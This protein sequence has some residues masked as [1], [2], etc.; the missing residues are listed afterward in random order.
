MLNH[1]QRSSIRI[2]VDLSA[3][4]FR[5]YTDNCFRFIFLFYHL[6]GFIF[7]PCWQQYLI[8][9]DIHLAQYT[10]NQVNQKKIVSIAIHVLNQKSTKVFLDY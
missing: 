3:L 2:V 5:S 1:T 10:Q 7:S 8:L 6:R 9:L 4:T